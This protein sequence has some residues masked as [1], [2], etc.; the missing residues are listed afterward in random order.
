[1]APRQQR[2]RWWDGINGSATGSGGPTCSTGPVNGHN[3]FSD[4]NAGGFGGVKVCTDGAISP[5]GQVGSACP[6]LAPV[7]LQVAR[8]R[9][10]GRLLAQGAEAD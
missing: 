10:Q 7:P 1:M 3:D 2:W 6:T 8:P 5:A 4:A 9:C